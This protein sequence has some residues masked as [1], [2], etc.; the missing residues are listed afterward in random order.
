[1]DNFLNQKSMWDNFFAL[2][3]GLVILVYS[4]DWFVRGTASIARGYGVSPLLI[5]L[6]VVGLGTSAPEIL[7]STLASMQGNT[8]LAVGNAIGS[9][10]ANIGLILGATALIA[11]IAVHSKM[12]KRELPILMVTSIFCYSLVYHDYYLG[13]VDGLLMLAALAVFFWWLIKTA[14]K[15][16][17]DDPYNQELEDEL[18]EVLSK[19]RAWLYF[20]VGLVGLLFSSKLLVW[21]GVGIAV[22]FGVTDLVIGLTIVALGTSLPELAASITSVLKKEDDL[23]IGNIIGSNMY[24]LLAVY[25]LPGIIAPGAVMNSVVT[26]DF[27]VMLVFTGILFFLGYGVAKEGKICRLE[28][29]ALLLGYVVYQWVI[30]QSVVQFA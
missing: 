11:P 18:P 26:R 29:A 8:G 24:N 2:L 28:G 13:V 3:V 23:A 25:A 1:M 10:I 9:N 4:A 19:T 22:Y 5:G 21:A 7:V 20:A 12:L 16:R 30:Y 17:R 14:F 6:T 15:E 27:P